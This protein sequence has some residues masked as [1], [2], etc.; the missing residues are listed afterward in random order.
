MLLN[1]TG[2]QLRDFQCVVMLDD[3]VVILVTVQ[4]IGIPY[5]QAVKVRNSLTSFWTVFDT[6]HPLPFHA[7]IK[8]ITRS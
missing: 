4:F 8:Q 3:F 5:M 6:A 1:L 7:F 2:S